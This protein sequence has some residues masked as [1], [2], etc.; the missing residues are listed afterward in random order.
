MSEITVPYENATSGE[1]ARA[2]VNVLLRRFGCDNIGWMD[3]H[4]QRTVILTFMHQGR[5][6]TLEASAAGWAAMFLR[7]RPWNRSRRL[8]KLA[9]TAKAHTQ[10]IVA[11]NSILRD[12]VKGQVTAIEC[13][14]LKFEDAF[15]PVALLPDGRRILD[16]VQAA[17]L[18]SPPREETNP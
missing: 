14:L 13:G 2:E 17:G 6:M 7:A 15:L 1:K 3:R 12:W 11:I 10:G 5:Q 4:E 8:D 16:V 18:L 9:Y